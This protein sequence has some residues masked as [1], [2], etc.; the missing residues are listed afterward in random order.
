MMSEGA[1][2]KEPPELD[3]DIFCDDVLASPEAMYHEVR[4]AAPVVRIV[5]YGVYATARYV[6][7][8]E[9]ITDHRRFTAESGVGLADARIEG[10]G[11]RPRSILVE[12]DPP[13]HTANRRAAMRV[14]SPPMI[15]SW[16]PMFDAVAQV[17][18]ERALEMGDI[19]GMD[20]V[21]GYLFDAFPKAMGIR[22]DPEAIRAIGFMT[23]NQTGPRNALYEAGMRAGEPYLRWFAESCERQNVVP[24]SF[25][26][27]MF[28]A[29]EAG[30]LHPGGA[31][32]IVRTFI[33][34][35]TDSTLSGLTTAMRELARN[36]DQWALL[37]ARPALVRNVLDEALRME[38]PTHILFRATNT[39]VELAGYR[40]K[41][42][43]KIAALFGGANH[44]PRQWDRPDAFD[45]TRNSAGVHLAFGTGIHNCIG[46][47]IARLEAESLLMAMIGRVRSISLTGPTHYRLFN[48]MRLQDVVPLHLTAS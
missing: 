11:A 45:L 39:D 6:E 36:P 5:P 3:V 10:S 1:D 12:S 26:D 8:I 2:P 37:K 42:N 16:R 25:A 48:A 46:Q 14:L 24:G 34:A 4:E 19:N 9:V 31:A 28:E 7:V 33:R 44:D 32:N 35:G 20:F 29:E 22:F 27:K 21:E 15:R 13:E 17:H 47:N 23:F 43:T 38:P 30:E 40:L 18:V 41:D